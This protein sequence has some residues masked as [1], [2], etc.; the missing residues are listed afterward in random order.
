MRT[1]R[2]LVLGLVC[3][4]CGDGDADGDGYPAGVDCDDADAGVHPD[5]VETCDG[6]DQ[7]CDGAN[8]DNLVPSAYETIL[9]A[10]EEVGDNSTICVEPGSYAE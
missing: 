1:F 3:V 10:V 6:V 4:A 9:S 2:L 8:D 7:D 5:A